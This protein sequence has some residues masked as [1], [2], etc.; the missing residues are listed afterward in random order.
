MVSLLEVSGIS[1]DF[2]AVQALCDV[3]FTAEAGQVV[4]LLG[5]NGA[6]KTT[7]L[8]IISTLL[9]PT[10]GAVRLDGLDVV[11]QT[12][13]VRQR[14]SVV[15]G[16]NRG[17]YGRLSGW[18]NA[19]FFGTL[20]G[21]GGRQLRSRCREALEAVALDEVASRA[22]DTYSS[23][24]RQRLHLA[25]GLLTTPKLLMLDEPTIGLDPVEAARLRTVVSGLAGQ[26]PCVLL[27]SHYLKDIEE[28]A[29]R[30]LILRRGR[31]THNLPLGELLGQAGAAAVV[32]LRGRGA[33]PHPFDAEPAS[34]V[35]ML[36]SAAD[37]PD[38]WVARFEIAEWDQR[39]L[40]ELIRRWPDGTVTDVR[41]DP[42]DLEQV[43]RD[44]SA[45]AP[46]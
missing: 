35:R 39:T 46:G 24:M 31:L 16:G 29:S 42:V 40:A 2:G 45:G 12:R 37:Q 18:D 25:I 41:V 3:S 10:A 4:G 33:A 34:G 17:L 32:T 36:D 22:V 19:R 11:T 14:L 15:F 7:L 9:L 38:S 23:G 6:G 28:L 21:L 20:A 27:T 30:V 44:L 5:L 43:F 1:R 13:A 8:K 26:G